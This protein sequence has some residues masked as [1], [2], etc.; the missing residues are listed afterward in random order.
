MTL[1]ILLIVLAIAGASY[2]ALTRKDVME[3]TNDY[4]DV[5]EGRKSVRKTRSDKGQ[6]RAPY[7]KRSK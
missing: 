6:K 4:W 2:W 1:I 5:Y 3:F 7:A